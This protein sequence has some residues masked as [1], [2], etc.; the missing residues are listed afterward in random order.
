MAKKDI[1]VI[2]VNNTEVVE[3]VEETAKTAGSKIKEVATSKPAMFG[4]G[5][6]ALAGIAF[7]IKKLV[8]DGSAN[9]DIVE[10]TAEDSES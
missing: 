1:E 7:G 3:A 6:V 10:E 5:A 4:L 2:E 8:F 9:D